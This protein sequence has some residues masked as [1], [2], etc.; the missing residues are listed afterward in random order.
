M[1]KNF[2]EP[3]SG[4]F[5]I[6]VPVDHHG[7]LSINEFAQH[8]TVPNKVAVEAAPVYVFKHIKTFMWWQPVIEKWCIHETLSGLHICSHDD[9][10]EAVKLARQLLR[11]AGE[12]TFFKTCS[13]YGDAR[14]HP[15]MTSARLFELQIEML[16]N[17]RAARERKEAQVRKHGFGGTNKSSSS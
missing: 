8:K 15:E 14:K 13:K 3:S 10:K 17:D 7:K 6:T 4:T 5:Y 2:T 1:S 12:E 11:N 16:A 9:K